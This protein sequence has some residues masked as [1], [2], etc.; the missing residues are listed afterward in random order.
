MRPSC[1]FDA[2]PDLLLATD[3]ANAIKV[4]PALAFRAPA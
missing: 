1:Q 3:T 2:G 4:L